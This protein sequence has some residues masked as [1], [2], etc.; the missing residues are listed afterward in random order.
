M[1]APTLFSLLIGSKDAKLSKGKRAEKPNYR[2]YRNDTMI[3]F[4]LWEESG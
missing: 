4:A 3:A 1:M 2:F